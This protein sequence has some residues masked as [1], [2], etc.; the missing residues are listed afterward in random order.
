MHVGI[1]TVC[2]GILIKHANATSYHVC[3]S[4]MPINSDLLLLSVSMTSE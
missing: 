3:I 1:K 2:E 4:H